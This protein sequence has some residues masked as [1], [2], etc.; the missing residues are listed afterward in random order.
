MQTFQYG[1]HFRNGR[2]VDRAH[3]LN[4]QIYVWTVNDS[5]SLKKCVDLEVDNIITDNVA[6]AKS[7][8]A[9]H[10]NDVFSILLNQLKESDNSKEN[11]KKLIEY[12]KMLQVLREH[13]NI[14]WG[15]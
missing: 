4:K 9:T 14:E 10:G 15:L 2:V 7:V 6:G 8:I 11:I 13:K 1:K 3:K 5:D 12:Q